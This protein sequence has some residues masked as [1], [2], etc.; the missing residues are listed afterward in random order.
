MRKGETEPAS[1]RAREIE[2]ERKRERERERERERDRDRQTQIETE[3]ERKRERES[4]DA[5]HGLQS[6]EAT[7]DRL[8]ALVRS[9][10]ERR[11]LFWD[12]PRVVYHRAYLRIKILTRPRLTRPRHSEP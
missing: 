9:H 2:R 7:P 3:R 4:Q 12:R 11:C 5:L 1:K 6:D 8:R 10:E